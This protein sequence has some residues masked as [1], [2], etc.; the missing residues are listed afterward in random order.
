MYLYRYFAIL[1][2]YIFRIIRRWNYI[3]LHH[4]FVFIVTFA[5]IVT[6]IV[7]LLTISFYKINSLFNNIW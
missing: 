2:Y 4:M 3:Q 5:T 7:G 1:A 6:L